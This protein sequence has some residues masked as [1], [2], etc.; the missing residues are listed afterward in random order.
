MPTIKKLQ[1]VANTLHMF[2]SGLFHLSRASTASSGGCCESSITF[3]VPSVLGGSESELK[4]KLEVDSKTACGL[5]GSLVSLKSLFEI[6]C[7]VV[8]I[9][10]ESMLHS[11]R[12]PKSHCESKQETMQGIGVGF[13]LYIERTEGVEQ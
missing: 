4:P 12:V 9:V 1:N 7:V 5:A 6:V 11:S 13:E 10:A 2:P 8:A 3:D